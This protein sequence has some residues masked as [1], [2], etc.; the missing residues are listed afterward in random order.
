MPLYEYECR[1]CHHRFEVIQSFSDKPIRKCP[2]CK[3]GTVQKLLSSPALRFKGSGFYITDYGGKGGA[4]PGE[5]T[6][7]SSGGESSGKDGGTA[8]EKSEKK[9]GE[10]SGKSSSG[11]KSGKKD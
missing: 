6:S 1:K 2:N 3:K 4:P 11:K 8:G 7:G 10:S 5:G 9:S